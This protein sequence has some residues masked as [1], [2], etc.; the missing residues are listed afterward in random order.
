MP[1]IEDNRLVTTNDKLVTGFWGFGDPSA[2]P[3]M[4]EES[5]VSGGKETAINSVIKK[6]PEGRMIALEIHAVG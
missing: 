5:H 2:P 6:A 3:S 4:N 1:G